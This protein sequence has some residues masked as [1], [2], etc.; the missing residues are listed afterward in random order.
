[1][2]GSERKRPTR[3]TRLPI[4][5]PPV[6]G[7]VGGLGPLGARPVREVEDSIY[8]LRGYKAWAARVKA[9]WDAES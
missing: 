1:M 6:T 7:R 8:T 5:P 2:A 3:R 4:P 9:A